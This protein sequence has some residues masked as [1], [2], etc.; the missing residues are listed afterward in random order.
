MTNKIYYQD[1]YIQSLTAE[2]HHQQ[3]D[4]EGR[5]YAVLDQTIFYP[6][7][8]GQPHDTGRLNGVK[9]YGVEEVDGEI[10]HYTEKEVHA[11]DGAAECEIDWGRRYDHMQQHAGQHLLSAVMEELLDMKTTSFHLGKE[12][13]T[14][15]LDADSLTTDM[16][17]RA[18][19][20]ANRIILQNHPIETK[21]VTAE[22]A[23]SYPLRKQLEATENIRLVI[24]HGCDYSGCG[25]T[26]PRST[27]EIASIKLLKWERQRKQVRLE[28]VC[29]N[30]VLKQL[31][32]KHSVI[33]ELTQVMNRPADQLVAEAKQLLEEKKALQAKLD[34]AE[35]EL[36]EVEAESMIDAAAEGNELIHQ[37]YTDRSIQ[38]L[39]QLAR[40]I[41]AKDPE[42]LVFLTAENGEQL[43][44]V[45]AR[46]KDR[47]E[48]L[49]KATQLIFSLIEGKGGG[50]PDFIQGGGKNIMSGAE[51]AKAFMQSLK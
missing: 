46:G 5:H 51:L 41:T 25:G 47:E 20:A 11:P 48:D 34:A 2:I 28:F 40:M 23:S 13:V 18:E 37:S 30:R 49:K 44:F 24:I 10:R 50:K 4:E 43:Q 14:I 31:G 38:T 27:G 16:M 12:T 15:D 19:K 1:A 21:W 22:E 39:Q 35:E 3:K 33:Q 45:T 42:S 29:G 36:L 6:T 32:E 8:G 9:V 26:H 7:G 17:D